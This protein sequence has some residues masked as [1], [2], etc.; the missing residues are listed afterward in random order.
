MVLDHT[1]VAATLDYGVLDR[2]VRTAA[3]GMLA[4]GARTGDRV[5][6]R[7]TDVVDHLTAVL[8]AMAA[9]LVAV[10][11]PAELAPEEMVFRAADADPSLLVLSPG[12]SGAPPGAEVVTLPEL[13]RVPPLPAPRD[14]A[15]DDPA[16]LIYTSGTSARPKGV[17]HAHRALWARR[18]MHAAWTGIGRDD[19][20]L[21]TGRL[22]WTY[23]LGVG[24]VDPWS[25]GACAALLA[26]RPPAAEWPEASRAAGATVLAGVPSLYRQMLKYAEVSPP[27]FGRLRHAL[28]AGEPLRAE[29][30]AS[31]TERTALPLLEALGMTEVS[32]Y[33][34]TGPEL[35]VRPGSP[36]KPQPGR[37]VAILPVERGEE[38]LAPGEVGLLAVRRDDPGLMLGYWRRP[39]EEEKVYRGQWFVGG[40]LAALDVD[41]YLWFHGRADDVMN[42]FGYRV[43][44]AEV[45][46]ALARHPDVAE[47]AVTEL[48]VG[49]GVSVIAA[50]VVRREGATLG[51]SDVLAFAAEHLSPFKRPRE[52]RFVEALPRGANGKVVR[53]LLPA[54]G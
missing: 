53:R 45:E 13:L 11:L 49:D 14:T 44:P 10:P 17:L 37:R 20:V 36:G 25:V 23:T 50:F 35:Q 48:R 18:V 9:G 32:T 2:R 1:R 38:P 39:D 43:S 5:V 27:A 29:L 8:A 40:D 51:S 15:A 19:V 52:V 46:A 31:W 21:H 24:A 47:V 3:A 22:G 26:E 6:V 4:R 12:L 34:S 16:L 41:G 42:A 33:V 28:A 30:H 54:G 7:T